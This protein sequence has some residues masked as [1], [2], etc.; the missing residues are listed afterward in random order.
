MVGQDFGNTEAFHLIIEGPSDNPE[1]ENG[2]LYLAEST[3]PASIPTERLPL[4]KYEV[5][6]SE[7]ERFHGCQADRQADDQ[8][9]RVSRE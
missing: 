3:R 5:T 7:A 8:T 1:R 9:S 2:P 4:A 6:S